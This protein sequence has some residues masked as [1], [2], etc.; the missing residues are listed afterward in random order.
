MCEHAIPVSSFVSKQH[1]RILNGAVAGTT[2]YSRL[3]GASG[4]PPEEGLYW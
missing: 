4:G 3:T 1:G 2:R